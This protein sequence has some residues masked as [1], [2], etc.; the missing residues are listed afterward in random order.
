MS[1]SRKYKH[2]LNENVF[3]FVERTSKL[4]S[5]EKEDDIAAMEEAY[6]SY[7]L[8]QLQEKGL[9][10][11]RIQITD[12][13]TGLY[14]RTIVQFSIHNHNNNNNNND[15]DGNSDHKFT[16]GDI[17]KFVENEKITG[18]VCKSYRNQL[19]V[20]ID[21]NVSIQIGKDLIVSYKYSLLLLIDTITYKQYER[22]LS[23][24]PK[25]N[26]GIATHLRDLLFSASK[27]IES[28]K[29]DNNGND[30]S[31]TEYKTISINFE[32]INQKLV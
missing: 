7:S 11:R 32:P 19:K 24:L 15:E 18:V 14:G 21:D 12:I 17:V 25:P 30:K 16:V 29:N 2:L 1:A 20:A 22:I 28:V 6:S 26:I 5:V 9:C 8:K 3:D 4:L 31:S 10:L 13:N 27:A 23:I